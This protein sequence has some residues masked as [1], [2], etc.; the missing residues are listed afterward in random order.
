[1]QRPYS[2]LAVPAAR[3]NPPPFDRAA[4]VNQAVLALVADHMR[5]TSD[6]RDTLT[7]LLRDEFADAERRIRRF[8][9]DS[10]GYDVEQLNAVA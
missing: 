7:S 1:V 9:S 10:R 3:R 4:V 2:K 6:L 8:T 5:G